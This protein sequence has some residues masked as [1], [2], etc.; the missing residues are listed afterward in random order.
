MTEESF[1]LKGERLELQIGVADWSCQRDGILVEVREDST[2]FFCFAAGRSL[3]LIAE[4]I[5]LLRHLVTLSAIM[6]S[7]CKQLS[8]MRRQVR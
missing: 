4:P 3:L 6:T 1:I 5:T 2:Y 8:Y 7:P